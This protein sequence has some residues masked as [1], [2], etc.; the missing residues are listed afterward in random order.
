M[1][2]EGHFDHTLHGQGQG[3]AHVRI[4]GNA[5]MR[6]LRAGQVGFI[7]ALTMIDD[8]R[9]IPCQVPLPALSCELTVGLPR[10]V[11]GGDV[12]FLSDPVQVLVEA[13]EQE[14]H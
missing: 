8:H 4:K 13:I 7:L 11:S 2:D 6:T 3:E 14:V 12:G 9:V 5:L 1:E 10:V